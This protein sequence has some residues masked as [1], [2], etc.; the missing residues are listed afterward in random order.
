[1]LQQLIYIYV[2]LKEHLLLL[3]FLNVKMVMLL[4]YIMIVHVQILDLTQETTIT[5]E[6]LIFQLEQVALHQLL[7]VLDQIQEQ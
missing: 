7:K 2:Q 6:I 4:F 3:T 1:M 5:L